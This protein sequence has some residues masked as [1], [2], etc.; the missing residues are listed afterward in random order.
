LNYFVKKTLQANPPLPT[1]VQLYNVVDPLTRMQICN[2]LL[3]GAT[4]RINADGT[5]FFKYVDLYDNWDFSAACYASSGVYVSEATKSLTIVNGGNLTYVFDLKYPIVG[6]PI[7]VL[8]IN[9]GMP[10]VKIAVDNG[11]GAPGTLYYSDINPIVPITNDLSWYVLN[12]AS[13]LT[14]AGQTKIYV[15]IFPTGGAECIVS[16]IY[17]YADL[18]TVDAER[19]IINPNGNNIMLASMQGDVNCYLSLYYRD[20]KWII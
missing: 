1:N 18:E 12:S 4:M 17:M 9:S 8:Y 19:A 16:A 2:T 3:P 13:N 20:R 6:V 14:L 11:S 15:Q 5:G 7:L 10:H